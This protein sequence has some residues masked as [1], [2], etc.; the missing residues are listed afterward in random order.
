MRGS[1]L[2]VG[3]LIGWLIDGEPGISLH[4]FWPPF[5]VLAVIALCVSIEWRKR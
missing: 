5:A 1:A 2:A 4:G 3:A